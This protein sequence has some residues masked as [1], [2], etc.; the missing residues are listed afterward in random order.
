MSRVEGVEGEK[1]AE[2]KGPRL[3][4]SGSK[5]N[6]GLVLLTSVVLFLSLV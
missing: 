6:S 4:K 1:K 3:R 5:G 2:R